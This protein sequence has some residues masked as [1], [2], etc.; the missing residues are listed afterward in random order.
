MSAA[1]E[2]PKR[3]PV[4][5]YMGVPPLPLA[6]GPPDEPRAPSPHKNRDAVGNCFGCGA[7]REEIDDGLAPACYEPNP[8]PDNEALRAL[9]RTIQRKEAEIENLAKHL[10]F[11]EEQ[12]VGFS[13]QLR[14]AKAHLEE[15]KASFE[16][17]RTAR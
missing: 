2:F 13:R 3:V 4:M 6:C 9:S 12:V 16:K 11:G 7:T 1:D 17:L 15:L 8:G 14:V 5:K 10:Q